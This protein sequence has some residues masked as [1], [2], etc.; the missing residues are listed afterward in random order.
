MSS[1]YPDYEGQK[2]R[3]YLTPDWAALVGKEK[4]FASA[5]GP[6]TWGQSISLT[7][8]VPTGKA[9]YIWDAEASSHASTSTD[10]DHHLYVQLVMNNGS[11]WSVSRQG[12]ASAKSVSAGPLVVDA[13]E[14][15]TAA[16]Y[17]WANV[18]VELTLSIW[19]YEVSV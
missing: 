4:I 7:Y 6:Y 11:G 5:E 13:G 10:Y 12:L 1:G 3:V 2:Q 18:A 15:F 17:N 9:L 14:T 16:A 19:A 8:L